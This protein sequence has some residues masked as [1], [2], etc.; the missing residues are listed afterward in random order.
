[1]INIFKKCL[2]ATNTHNAILLHSFRTNVG[3]GGS[4][5]VLTWWIRDFKLCNKKIKT[6]Y[7]SWSYN[8]MCN[9]RDLQIQDLVNLWCLKDGFLMFS[10]LVV[11]WTWISHWLFEGTWIG[12]FESELFSS[13]FFGIP[14][15]VKAKVYYYIWGMEWCWWW[16]NISIN[17]AWAPTWRVVMQVRW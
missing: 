1:M 16:L 10:S 5:V 3:V 15:H 7:V 2:S 6:S 13:I 12:G 11:V 4:I 9:L 8:M 14:C 17:L